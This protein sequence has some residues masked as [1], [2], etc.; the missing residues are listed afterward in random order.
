MYCYNLRCKDKELF[1]TIKAF[2]Q[3]IIIGRNTALKDIDSTGG[4]T[5]TVAP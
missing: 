3:K 5:S 2:L 4:S 1:D